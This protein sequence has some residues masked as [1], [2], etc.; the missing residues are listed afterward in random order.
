VTRTPPWLHQLIWLRWVLGVRGM[1]AGGG[2]VAGLVLFLL[3]S[4]PGSLLMAGGLLFALNY[5]Q[6]VAQ[7]RV[8]Q[9]ALAALYLW[10]LA[11][12]LVGYAWVEI[13]AVAPMLAYPITPRQLFLGNVVS[14]LVQPAVLVAL[15][16]FLA[17]AISPLTMAG[18]LVGVVAVALLLVH[19][20]GMS[21][22]LSMVLS[23]AFAT[24]RARDFGF[25]IAT[26]LPL[27]FSLVWV[28]FAQRLDQGQVQI[29]TVL[30]HPAWGVVSFLPPGWAAMAIRGMMR[31]D[32]PAVLLGL[33][34]LSAAVV[35]TLVLGGVAV[36]RA[37]QGEEGSESAATV[38]ATVA[39]RGVVRLRDPVLD[40]LV[41]KELVLLWRDPRTR[42]A[43]A[44]TLFTVA[45]MAVLHFF[46]VRRESDL[47]MEVVVLRPTMLA[48]AAMILVM[49]QAA[50]LMN[51][52]GYEG[53]GL[54]SVFVTPAPR[55]KILAA[56]N[57]AQVSVM[58]V[59]DGLGL[60]TL[61]TIFNQVPTAVLIWLVMV[62]L[63]MLLA[64]G[65]NLVSVLVP[66]PL[67]G[68]RRRSMRT[69]PIWRAVMTEL[70]K[71]VGFTA[72]LAV[73]LPPGMV[74]VA[75]WAWSPAAAVGL[76]ALA[77]VYAAALYT[78]GLAAASALL[79]RRESAVAQAVARAEG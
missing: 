22:V 18:T 4:V 25:L 15:P 38:S 59:L 2:R 42:M 73:A 76:A 21:Q 8:L 36:R 74:V 65:G 13:H 41:N 75:A 44:G 70:L 5:L 52:F 71:L 12:P 79:L 16:L 45:L 49:T 26:L 69:T 1:T 11:A 78:V 29:S 55:W 40:A 47:A 14:A 60:L 43:M 34:L 9:G 19:L 77:L 68:L 3:A 54:Q 48:G 31:H 58:C 28:V 32:V 30:E 56:K 20:L 7:Q 66:F 51:S 46:V 61:G 50:Q 17:L 53:R 67:M 64:A 33:G 27:G 24:R 72:L 37:A 10:G 6:G 62:V 35:V 23:T 57:V 63:L 39:R